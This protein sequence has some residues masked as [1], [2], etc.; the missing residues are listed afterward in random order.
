MPVS[1]PLLEL[2][3]AEIIFAPFHDE[4]I[5]VQLPFTVEAGVPRFR[6]AHYW[7]STKLIWDHA[8]V[9]DTVGAI[10]LELPELPARFDEYIFCLVLP[11][12]VSVR[13]EARRPD[14]WQSLG[15]A[16]EGRGARS[17]ITRAIGGWRV[18]ALRATFRVAQPGPGMVGLH[19]WGAADAA[20]ARSLAA[21]RPQY[22]AKWEGL[23]LPVEEWGEVKFARGLL[24][25]AAD[26]PRLRAKAVKPVWRA[27]LAEIEKRARESL[28]LAPE[29]DIDDYLPWSD[30]RYLRAREQ[31]RATWFAEPVLCALIGL[32]REDTGLIRH[33]LRYLMCFAHTRHWCQSAESR[34]RGSTWDQ[35]CFLEEM[36]TT[37]CALLY[38]WLHF[39]LTERARDLVRTAI[40][41]KGVSVIQRDMVKWEYVYTMNQGPWFCRARIFGALVLEPSWPRVR[42]YVEQAFNDLREGMDHYLLPDGGVDEGVGYFSVTLQAVLP[43]LLA[44]ARA[45]GHPLSEVLPPRLA[46]S[47]RFVATM[48]AMSS[49]GV[50]MDGD[51]S[52]DRFTGDTIA[53][54]AGLFPD[55]VYPRIA[56]ATLLQLRGATYYR[57]YMIDGPFAFIAAPDDLPAPECVVPTFGVLPHTGQLTS[58]REMTPG[59]AVRLHLSGCKARASH[60]HFDKGAFTLELDTTPVLIDRGVVRYD[61]PRTHTMKRSELHNIAGPVRPDGGCAQQ[62]S[63]EVA[64]IPEGQGDARRLRARVNLAHVWREVATVAEREIVADDPGRFTVIDRF[65]LKAAGPVVFH[66]HSRVPWVIDETNQRAMLEIPGWRLTLE[67]PWAAGLR[68]FQDG[69]DHRYEPVWH[70]ECVAAA[71]RNFELASRFT[72]ETKA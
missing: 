64:V 1:L 40:W 19:W 4:R 6:H 53:I 25:D 45:S 65:S 60:T 41:D 27:H 61:D 39:A 2:N 56:Q 48:S 37:T 49:G 3:P 51:N 42:P 46:L 62:S 29:T 15:D 69:I 24:F 26:L 31:G 21:A 54:L 63:P 36:A 57:Q 70:L 67:V 8:A 58:R 16:V 72:C 28:G 22:D 43:G 68:Q 35:R 47:G 7:D 18:T 44:Y 52:N 38:D 23:I 30:Y 33:A 9:G 66:L 20:L 50:L 5:A 17:E 34:A 32:L 13:F 11:T 14:G 12:G 10:S 55:D 59:R 71:A